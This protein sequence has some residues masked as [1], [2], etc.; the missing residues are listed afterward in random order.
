MFSRRDVGSMTD[1]IAGFN[2]IGR[3]TLESK[4]HSIERK[5]EEK[6]EPV[7]LD[8]ADITSQDLRKASIEYFPLHTKKARVEREALAKS[9]PRQTHEIIIPKDKTEKTPR[10]IPDTEDKS[11]SLTDIMEGGAGIKPTVTSQADPG[12]DI[13]GFE[14][15]LSSDL[16]PLVRVQ[17]DW[18]IEGLK[19][20]IPTLTEMQKVFE[21]VTA[22]KTIPYEFLP[23]G[24]YARGHVAAEKF[25]NKD[26]NCAKLYVM[27]SDVDFDDPYYPFPPYRLK[28]K[29]KFTRGEWW[30]HVAPVTFAKD[31]K[32]GK[33]D[34]YV[35]DPA[36]DPKK[37]IKAANWIK[38]FWDG[39]FK[40]QFD[41]TQADIYNP[42]MEDFQ[43]YQPKEFDRKRFD[44]YL[45]I[46]RKTNKEYS[47]VLAKIKDEYYEEHPDEKPEE[48]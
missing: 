2:N 12:Y 7:I 33:I 31:E 40:I 9:K 25:I 27:L 8:K 14:K 4:T 39:T 18:D 32:T 5:K 28:A 11:P 47:E 36:V 37:P 45:P 35:I 22:D 23:D 43:D 48:A 6:K 19:G 13:T 16:G 20:K 42:P 44:K 21:E 34:G 26:I 17:N 24:C 1:K 46:A 38:A 15:Q 41:T 10:F 3:I 30:Y 29:N